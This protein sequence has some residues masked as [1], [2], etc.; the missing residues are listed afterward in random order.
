M[1]FFNFFKKRKYSLEEIFKKIGVF[2]IVEQSEI[3]KEFNVPIFKIVKY[4]KGSRISEEPYT[5]EKYILLKEKYPIVFVGPKSPFSEFPSNKL[6]LGRLELP[7][8]GLT[9]EEL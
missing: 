4:F 1:I 3:A 7:R 6:I 5:D 8:I 9:E 2:Y